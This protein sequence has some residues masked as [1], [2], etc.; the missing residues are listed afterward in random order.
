[1]GVGVPEFNVK[2]WIPLIP[3]NTWK[4]GET[5]KPKNQ[6]RNDQPVLTVASRNPVGVS[7]NVFVFVRC[8]LFLRLL[9]IGWFLFVCW[10][11]SFS[12]YYLG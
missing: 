10:F 4:N 9:R 1:M 5:K 2:G 12:K 8:C 3:S 7:C 6:H 11:L